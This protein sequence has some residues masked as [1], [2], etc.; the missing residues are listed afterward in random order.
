MNY[1]MEWVWIKPI[2]SA[3]GYWLRFSQVTDLKVL[4]ISGSDYEVKIDGVQV[5]ADTLTA[6]DAEVCRYFKHTTG[7]LASELAKLKL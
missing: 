5:F 2:G 4:L 7:Y 6:C 1:I 3:L